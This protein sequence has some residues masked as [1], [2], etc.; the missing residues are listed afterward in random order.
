MDKDINRV[1]VDA[2]AHELSYLQA[3][4]EQVRR[5]ESDD[6]RRDILAALNRHGYDD[7]AR[8]SVL[9]HIVQMLANGEITARHIGNDMPPHD[10]GAVETHPDK[11]WLSAVD[12]R[13][14]RSTLL[15]AGAS[16]DSAL[17]L[18]LDAACK[19]LGRRMGMSVSVTDLLSHAAHG[20]IMLHWDISTRFLKGVR[21]Y[22]AEH[23]NLTDASS[24]EIVEDVPPGNYE[25][26]FDGLETPDFFLALANDEASEWSSSAPTLVSPT[27][28]SFFWELLEGDPNVPEWK[29]GM[30]D[31]LPSTQIPSL[32]EL[33]VDSTTLG[34]FESQ[35]K[36][37]LAAGRGEQ[38]AAPL[39][40]AETHDERSAPAAD[41]VCGVSRTTSAPAIPSPVI[42]AAF[43][44]LNGWNE[45]QWER[46]LGDPPEWLKRARI[47]P[48]RRGKGGAATWNPV[49]IAA[50]LDDMRCAR[51][52]L[53]AV[54]K[55]PAMK[56][57]V[58]EWETKSEMLS[59]TAEKYGG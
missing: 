13:K 7:N 57:W 3:S 1:T 33:R 53:N 46:Y 9:R 50:A 55:N 40:R 17:Y 21:H 5:R 22:D 8:P 42:A 37:A 59:S 45:K 11:Y 23:A 39:A 38:G 19:E 12:V 36:R 58:S 30:D 2:L 28:D 25:I 52:K 43:D 44:S 14:V 6:V 29:R 15:P 49:I 54:F 31:Y 48:G 27:N 35:I 51:H 20:P 26:Y 34:N 4:N 16:A 41:T 10:V 32:S 24:A 18:S 47:T 56:A